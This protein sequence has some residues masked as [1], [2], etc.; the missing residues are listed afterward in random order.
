MHLKYGLV[1]R[2]N[3]STELHV[4]DAVLVPR[5]HFRVS[6]HPVGKI[7]CCGHLMRLALEKASTATHEDSVTSEHH[8]VNGASHLITCRKL[9]DLV[10][11]AFC[12][13]F[14]WLK[15]V[16]HVTTGVARRMEAANS[17]AV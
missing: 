3:S 13:T 8:S 11:L 2:V 17:H 10:I 12:N 14:S 6:W 5:E 7:H 15:Q 4:G 1:F 16:E 9:V